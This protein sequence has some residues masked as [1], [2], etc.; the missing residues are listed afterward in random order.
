MYIVYSDEIKIY[1][2]KLLSRDKDLSYY[3]FVCS[4]TYRSYSEDI[5]IY[6]DT[7]KNEEE[8]EE[9]LSRVIGAKTEDEAFRKFKEYLKRRLNNEG[10]ELI[11]RNMV[12]FIKNVR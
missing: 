2:P 1:G 3:H 6:R 10:F 5:D 12:D 11:K 9:T 4:Y 7:S 8:G